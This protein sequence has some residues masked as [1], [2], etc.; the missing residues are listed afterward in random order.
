MIAARAPAKSL[1]R[2]VFCSVREKFP[3]KRERRYIMKTKH[4]FISI[5]AVLFAFPLPGAFAQEAS[6]S[7]SIQV[8]ATFDYP[9][10]DVTQTVPSGINDRNDITGFYVDSNGVTRGFVRFGN[11]TFSAPIVEP[12]DTVGFTEGR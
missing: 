10:G 12:K 3:E 9:G 11:G 2:Q 6:D 7:I 5:L 1:D 8:I 4:L